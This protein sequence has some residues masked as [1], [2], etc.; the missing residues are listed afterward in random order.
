VVLNE[1]DQI[2]LGGTTMVFSKE[3][4]ASQQAAIEFV[5]QLGER[6]VNTMM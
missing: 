2:V 4:F 6:R 3:R 1:G 5:K